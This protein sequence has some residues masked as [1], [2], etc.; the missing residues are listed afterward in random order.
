MGKP[1]D[2][3]DQPVSAQSFHPKIAGARLYADSPE[4]TLRSVGL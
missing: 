2:D 4:E 1:P 3:P